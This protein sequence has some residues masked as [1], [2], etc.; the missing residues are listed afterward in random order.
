MR[1]LAWLVRRKP[2]DRVFVRMVVEGVKQPVLVG[3][4]DRF[5]AEILLAHALAP[6]PYHYGRRVLSARIHGE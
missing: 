2:V 3:P 4:M 1:W 6:Y 5:A